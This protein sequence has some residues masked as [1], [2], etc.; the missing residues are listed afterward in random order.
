VVETALKNGVIKPAALQ[1]DPKNPIRHGFDY[2][3]Q[4]VFRRCP[5]IFCVASENATICARK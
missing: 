3:Y 2:F 5:V 4:S 1:T